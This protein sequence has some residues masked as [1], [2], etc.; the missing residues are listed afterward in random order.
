M[1][2]EIEVTF[3][4]TYKAFNSDKIKDEVKCYYESKCDFLSYMKIVEVARKN[5]G[6]TV[7][8]TS[9]K[10]FWKFEIITKH[11]CAKEVYIIKKVTRA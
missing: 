5:C 3:K 1:K 6:Y 9:D 10:E 4:H 11:F 2:Y 8:H 7:Y